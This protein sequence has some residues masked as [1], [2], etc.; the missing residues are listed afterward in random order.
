MLFFSSQVAFKNVA[1][2]IGEIQARL[3]TLENKMEQINKEKK[4]SVKD[5]VK[6]NK[7]NPNVNRVPG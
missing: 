5:Q 2:S 3:Q 4:D 1:K 7:V 6:S